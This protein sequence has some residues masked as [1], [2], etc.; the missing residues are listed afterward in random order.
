M[1]AQLQVPQ[2]C[3]AEHPSIDV[4]ARRQKTTSTNKSSRKI[5]NNR[6][7]V[8]E[9]T[10]WSAPGLSSLGALTSPARGLCASS[11]PTRGL[12]RFGLPP[13]Q[14]RL[15]PSPA[16]RLT[17]R[18]LRRPQMD[19]G[20]EGHVNIGAPPPRMSNDCKHCGAALSSTT[21]GALG[22]DAESDDLACDRHLC[23]ES[24]SGRSKPS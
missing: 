18:P 15:V 11:P 23:K 10:S 5:Y 14:E 8:R 4:P 21:G 17:P 6:S 19:R 7:E 2:R 9:P 16:R 20:D 1:G 3:K 22:V 13:R 24:E 12:L